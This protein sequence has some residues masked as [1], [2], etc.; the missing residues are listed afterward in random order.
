[1]EFRQTDPIRR[2][3]AGLPRYE[4]P[5]ELRDRLRV[6]G[7]K[8]CARRRRLR[9]LE[10]W[11]ADFA[12]DVRLAFHNLMRPIALPMAGGLSSALVLFSLVAPGLA[13]RPL[14]GSIGADD[15][16]TGLTTVATVSSSVSFSLDHR[17]IVIDVFI[18]ENGRVMD[19]SIP[20]GQAWTRDPAMVRNITNTLLCTRFKAATWFG[21]K[22]S[23]RT[24]ITLTA[25]QLEVRG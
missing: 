20:A 15:V 23:G 10:T 7:S 6:M 16:D 8:E 12:T 22:A 1:M 24:R 11:L 25:S 9:D 21:K 18:D 4:L 2:D 19:Y 3:L 17:D 14:Q 13:S 5:V